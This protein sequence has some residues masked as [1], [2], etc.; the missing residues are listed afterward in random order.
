MVEKLLFFQKN[1]IR[2]TF[3]QKIFIVIPMPLL[4]NSTV[5][6]KFIWNFICFSCCNSM[7]KRVVEICRTLPNNVKEYIPCYP[8]EPFSLRTH[9]RIKNFNAEEI[10]DKRS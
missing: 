5:K 3:N 2:L 9:M 8:F 10:L 6:K 1:K 4:N 7:V